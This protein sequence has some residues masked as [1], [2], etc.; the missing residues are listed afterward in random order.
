MSTNQLAF[1]NNVI[2][3]LEKL[4]SYFCKMFG[5]EGEIYM[6]SIPPQSVFRTLKRSGCLIS[7]K[8]SELFF[9]GENRA[10]V[11]PNG[12]GSEIS[13]GFT[14]FQPAFWISKRVLWHIRRSP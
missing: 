11:L 5:V 3:T 4:F 9:P 12:S 6:D 8:I 7:S 10:D 1:F 2:H 14:P 13:E